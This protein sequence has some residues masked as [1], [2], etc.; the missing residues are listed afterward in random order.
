MFTNTN[1][2]SN[3][4]TNKVCVSLSCSVVVVPRSS[5]FPVSPLPPFVEGDQSP[6]R[7]REEGRS[8]RGSLRTL[9]EGRS[10]AK[11]WIP[12]TIET[13]LLES[14]VEPYLYRNH[15]Y[16]KLRRPGSSPGHWDLV[17]GRTRRY[18]LVIVRERSSWSVRLLIYHSLRQKV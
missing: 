18:I 8:Q 5:K 2:V 6:T 16:Q 1:N 9:M 14:D 11:I 12:S 7:S 17:R 13:T 4:A 10:R 15:L 3:S